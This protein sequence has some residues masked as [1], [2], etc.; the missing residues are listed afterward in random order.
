MKPLDPEERAALLGLA[1]RAL[2]QA[3]RLPPTPPAAKA[4][5][6]RAGVFVTWTVDGERRGSLGALAPSAALEQELATLAVRAALE[7]P[8]VP[9]ISAAEAPRARCTV[10]LAGPA[11]PIAGPEAIDVA[12]HGLSVVNGA[13]AAVL[14]PS[15]AVAQGWDAATYLKH[16]CL[17]AGLR[18]DASRLPDTRVLAFEVVEVSDDPAAGAPASEP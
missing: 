15:A 1:H 18:A 4:P 2:A 14:L 8:R 6:G 11:W 12:R 3:L 16:T 17:R 7:D 5:A 13:H 10:A 9:P